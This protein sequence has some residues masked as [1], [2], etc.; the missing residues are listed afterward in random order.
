M[1]AWGY[2][3][4]TVPG[5]QP[6]RGKKFTPAEIRCKG[7]SLVVKA[8]AKLKLKGRIKLDCKETCVSNQ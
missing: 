5:I 7:L 2:G 1:K 8:K 3:R 4:T 6:G